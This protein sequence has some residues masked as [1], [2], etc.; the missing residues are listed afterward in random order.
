MLYG[1]VYDVTDFQ[2]DHPGGPDVLQDIAGQDATEEF[3]NIVHTEKAT[4]MCKKYLKGK[5]KDAQLGNLFVKVDEGPNNTGSETKQGNN[6]GS[7]MTKKNVGA[8][9]I[10]CILLAVK[11]FVNWVYVARSVCFNI[12]QSIYQISMAPI[13]PVKPGSVVR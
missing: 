4:K 9:F 11:L 6:G 3:E 12:N 2:I 13:S 7:N 1:R 5:V 10:V 8:F